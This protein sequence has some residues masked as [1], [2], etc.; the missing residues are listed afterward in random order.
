[1]LQAQAFGA[2]ALLAHRFRVERSLGRGGSGEVHAAYDVLL[3]RPVALK[4]LRADRTG[5]DLEEG[6]R[7]EFRTLRALSHPGIV[8]VFDFGYAGG[9]P[10]YTMELLPGGDLASS[11]HAPDPHLLLHEVALALDYLHGFG[12]VHSDLKPS[13]VFRSGAHLK[14][15][16]FGLV[17]SLRAP[18]REAAYGTLAY[19]PPERLRAPESSVDP[20]GDLYALGAILY[21]SLVGRPPY[22]QDEAGATAARI[23]LGNLDEELSLVPEPWPRLLRRLLAGDPAARFGSAWELL[24]A[25]AALFERPAPTPASHAA[26]FVGRRRELA[27]VRS[28]LG[29]LSRGRGAFVYAPGAPGIG[30]T[31]L[32]DAAV[33]QAAAAGVPLWP[34]EPR[35]SGGGCVIATSLAQLH[36]RWAPVLPP[37]A[38]EAARRLAEW[39]RALANAT[40][41]E[42]LLNAHAL[43]LA[44]LMDLARAAP[45]VILVD[46]AH[47]LDFASN[48][49]LKFVAANARDLQILWLVSG[50]AGPAASAG[51]PGAL[52]PALD[53]LR[54][55]DCGVHVLP[56]R[57]FSPDET[58]A[59]V[60]RRLGTSAELDLLAQRIHAQSQG[61]PL[62]ASE[63]LRHAMQTGG[64]RRQG[65][66][67]TVDLQNAPEPAPRV[68]NTI[69]TDH[70]ATV[71]AA[72]RVA[73]EALALLPGGATAALLA[74]A[75]GLSDAAA[76]ESLERGV[77]AGL[78]TC[79]EGTFQF[80]HELIREACAGRHPEADA[81]RIHGALAAARAGTAAEAEHRLR[82][83]DTSPEARACYLREAARCDAQRATRDALPL[84]EAALAIAPEAADAEDLTLRVAELRA[85]SGRIDGACALLLERLV[86][87]RRPLLRARYLHRLGDAYHRQGRNAEALLH[88]Q[89]A[90][91][92]FHKHA[93]PEECRRF[94]VDLIRVLITKGDLAQAVEQCRQALTG[95]PEPPA[96]ARGSMLLLLAQA[97]RQ[98]GGHQAAEAA[99]R[100]ALEALKPLGRTLELAQA[101]TQIGTSY[102]YRRDFEQAERFHRAALKLLRELGDVHGEKNAYNNLGN[103]LMRAGRWAD[104]I[105]SYEK[106]LELNRRLGDRP[107]EGT[108][109]NNLGNLWERRGEHRR[110]FQCYRRGVGIYRRLQRPRELATL[111]NN[112]AEVHLR[113]GGYVRALRLLSRALDLTGATPGAFVPLVVTLNQAEAH[114][115][116][117][118]ARAA[119]T[120]LQAILPHAAKAGLPDLLV[121]THSQLAVAHALD[122]NVAASAASSC[123][124]QQ[125][126]PV[127]LELETRVHVLLD[128]GKAALRRGEF[129]A[130]RAG[131]LEAERTAAA[132]DWPHPRA[133]ALRLL[134]ELER[135]GGQWDRAEAR[136]E[137]ALVHARNWGSRIEVARCHRELARVHWDLGLHTRARDELE[138]CIGLLEGLDLRVELGLAYLQL[139]R[140]APGRGG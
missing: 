17:Q 42:G 27:L 84:Y 60:R 59:L 96:A 136:L 51:D 69:L 53:I 131:L 39:P 137:E 62:F 132:Q 111:Y 66:T 115:G 77:G 75:L 43:A 21:E 107:R 44:D 50:R 65:R 8:Q 35:D 40:S 98:S 18:R 120:A 100:E 118:D 135:E 114:I 67:W 30:K 133:R 97:E 38:R 19:M 74:R 83:G 5:P 139:V 28:A 41:Q 16:D 73:C 140:M 129:H 14:L 23:A 119:I 125:A 76:L 90:T 64:L 57:E 4:L 22:V 78:L 102:N 110:A 138:R 32:L 99:A 87:V 127:D 81:R 2:G 34:V 101:Y 20:R 128:L 108:S 9:V 48:A 80:A 104:A 116:L 36:T 63:I 109:L 52:P 49:F 33:A 117:L 56:L 113:L 26:P 29:D 106:S 103:T 3:Q 68:A 47:Q 94:T 11:E 122:G 12:L 37:P 86:T 45:H 124:A 112:M 72:D 95:T 61:H 85:L 134:G 126:M 24:L 105:A 25:W 10:F 15:T 7:G 121:R 130:A 55:D 31:A 1:M 88:L 93:D 82:A 123:L 13:N 92:L 54:H 6:L 79:A 91:E 58:T 70:L 46:D 89:S 71:P